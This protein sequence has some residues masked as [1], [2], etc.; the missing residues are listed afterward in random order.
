[1]I[2]LVVLV[3]ACNPRSASAVSFELAAGEMRCVGEMMLPKSLLTGDWHIST[4]SGNT[5]SGSITMQVHSPAFAQDAEHGIMYENKE[6]SG[7][8]SVTAQMSGMH[9]VCIRNN[10][11]APRHATLHVKT[12][13]EVE[14]HSVVAKKEHVEA[15]E[16]ELDRMEQM[17]THV[18]EE[19]NY[20]RSRSDLMQSTDASTRGRLLWVE[21]AM[22]CTLLVM[23]LWQI[24]YLKR[25]FQQKKII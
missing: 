21:V 24:H 2:R 23:G 1:M 8:F 3:I 13:L 12:A 16:A 7:H 10:V 4:S 5:T 18:Y 9:Q 14:D 25:Y 15:I 17:A 6:P 11:D 22:L 19:M 20:M